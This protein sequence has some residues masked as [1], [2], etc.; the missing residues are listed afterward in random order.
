[1]F[2]SLIFSLLLFHRH[3]Y[4]YLILFFLFITFLV[5]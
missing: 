4:P 1:L 3:Q 5:Q 2:L